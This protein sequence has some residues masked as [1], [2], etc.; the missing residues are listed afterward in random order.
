[1]RP[2]TKARIV[3]AVIGAGAMMMMLTGCCS[4]SISGGNFPPPGATATSG[5]P[6]CPSPKVEDCAL[7]NVGSPQKF[8]CKGK[9]YTSFDLARMRTDCERKHGAQ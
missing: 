6:T 3:A 4:A 2:G 8:V 1:M 5:K 9:P 7:T